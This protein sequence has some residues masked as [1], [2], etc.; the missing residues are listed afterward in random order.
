M[1]KSGRV[2]AALA[3]ATLGALGSSTI[4]ASAAL[5]RSCPNAATTKVSASPSYSY[6]RGCIRS[7]DGTPIVYNLFEPLNPRAHSLYTILSGPGWGG[8]GATSPDEKLIKNGYAE[9]TW[10]P[11]GFGQSGGVAE[12]DSPAS[13][14]R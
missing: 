7:F 9:L 13:E 11:R 3:A 14:G 5:A 2:V 1:P 6:T 4:F 12:V 10:D 8:G